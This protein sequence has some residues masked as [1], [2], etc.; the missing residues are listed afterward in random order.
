MYLSSTSASVL[1]CDMITWKY[2]RINFPAGAFQIV[3][4]KSK[5]LDVP[6]T[7]KSKTWVQLFTPT[8]ILFKVHLLVYFLEGAYIGNGKSYLAMDVS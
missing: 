6:C 5:P 1:F 4:A 7:Q 2:L 8:D 3:I